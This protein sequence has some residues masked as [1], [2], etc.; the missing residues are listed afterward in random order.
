[1]EK[2]SNCFR[3]SIAAAAARPSIAAG[4]AAA[5]AAAAAAEY[6]GLVA[7]PVASAVQC[8]MASQG[9]SSLRGAGSSD[10]HSWICCVPQ[11]LGRERDAFSLAVRLS[12]VGVLVC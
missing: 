7:T 2:P 5:A 8:D 4:A 3:P 10:N 1:M 11:F 9:T 6:I 12:H